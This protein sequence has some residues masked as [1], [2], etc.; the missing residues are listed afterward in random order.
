MS[1]SSANLFTE[2]IYLVHQ[3]CLPFYVYL[4]LTPKHLALGKSRVLQFGTL[5]IQKSWE[6]HHW[7]YCRCF[8][9]SNCNRTK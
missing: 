6:W 3:L 8:Q 7:C 4:M 5:L 1:F 9:R 2:F